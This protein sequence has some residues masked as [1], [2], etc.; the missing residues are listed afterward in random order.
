MKTG[1]SAHSGAG[2]LFPATGSAWDVSWACAVDAF[3]HEPAFGKKSAEF[4]KPVRSDF[5]AAQ[6]EVT[7]LF[8]PAECRQTFIGQSCV[9]QA[10]VFQFTEFGQLVDTRIGNPGVGQLQRPEFAQRKEMNKSVIGNTG[11][12]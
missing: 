4:P 10:E 9:I 11:A 7:Q 8:Q 1:K 6:V 5:C 3:K 2:C 12:A